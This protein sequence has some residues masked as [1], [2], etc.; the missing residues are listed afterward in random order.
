MNN[1]ENTKAL[2]TA[3]LMEYSCYNRLFLSPQTCVEIVG[4]MMSTKNFIENYQGSGIKMWI[5]DFYENRRKKNQAIRDQEDY[6]QSIQNIDINAVSCGHCGQTLFHHIDQEDTIFCH[7][8]ET[9][10]ALSDCPDLLY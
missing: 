7:N 1:T 9:E 4:Q 6:L 5:I 8:C 3:Y 2:A 10:M